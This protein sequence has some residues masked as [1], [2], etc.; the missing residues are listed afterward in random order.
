M[1]DIRHKP[2][3]PPKPKP[4]RTAK[5][6]TIGIGIIR[7]TGIVVASDAQG[8]SASQ[9]REVQKIFTFGGSGGA[10][11]CIAGAA[12]P[13]IYVKYAAK[14]IGASLPSLLDSGK[15]LSDGIESA[16]ADIYEKHIYPYKGPEENRP[17]FNL[18][19]AVRH[20]GTGL[21]LFETVE[22]LAEEIQM[23]DYGCVGTGS[24]LAHYI[25]G[26]LGRMDWTVEEA[27]YLAVC[28]VNAANDYDPNCGKGIAL[29][30]VRPD[31]TVEVMNEQEITNS[32]SYFAD[33]WDSIGTLLWGMNPSL[34]DSIVEE[35]LGTL[36]EN[37][38]RFR[39][40][41]QALTAALA[42]LPSAS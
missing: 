14:R 36:R 40:K 18:L 5:A 20:P 37:L 16:L 15:N 34:D 4:R 3:Y 25:M 17:C 42:K 27:K 12:S 31:G 28:A 33:L 9:K 7:D 10:A 24:D 13:G 11:L 39:K 6:M 8:T 23:P 29:R 22:T 32:K 41:Q 19:I 35:L 30:V 2:P 26:T 1:I 38:F 21:H